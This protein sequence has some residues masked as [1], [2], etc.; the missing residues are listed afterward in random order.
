VTYEAHPV[1]TLLRAAVVDPS[2]SYADVLKARQALDAAI[3]A[4]SASP[5]LAP[6]RPSWGP[7]WRRIATAGAAMAILVTVVA[8]TTLLA[9][10][11]VTALGEL[12]TI[13]EQRDAV[14]A[15]EGE[16]AYSRSSEVSTV[17]IDG[18]DIGLPERGP[19]AFQLPRER[20]RW[21]AP[22]GTLYVRLEVG[23]PEFFDAEA[24]AA[25][26]ASGLARDFGIGEVDERQVTGETSLLDQRNWPT[27]AGDLLVAMRSWVSNEGNAVSETAAIVELAADLLRET[28]ADPELRSAVLR[29]LD[30]LGLE[31][32]VDEGNGRTSVGIQYVDTEV[33]RLELQF[34]ADANLVAERRI[35]VFDVPDLGVS[36]GTVIDQ[37]EY[38]PVRTV[39]SIGAG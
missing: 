11:P 2:P 33:V 21:Q 30:E 27:D 29:A 26:A 16:S 23:Q 8:V 25:F 5:V 1:D 14:I 10:E 19:I 36:A 38:S 31:T 34:D 13:A 4:E 28:G 18:A 20:E 22:D 6:A 7:W 39:R 9:P 12:A 35:W 15:G 17:F 32:A 24:A 37:A 3:A